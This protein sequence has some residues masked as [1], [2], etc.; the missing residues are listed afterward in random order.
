MKH[1]EKILL[2]AL[3]KEYDYLFKKYSELED[4]YN[5]LLTKVMEIE[6]DSMNYEIPKE[7]SVTEFT[8]N[9]R[10]HDYE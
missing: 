5:R 8:Y 1:D 10:G 9:C 7:D 6:T 4:K 3:D 2:L